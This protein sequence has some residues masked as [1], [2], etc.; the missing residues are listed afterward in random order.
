MGAAEFEFGAVPRSWRAMRS[1]ASDDHLLLRQTDWT[2]ETQQPIWVLVPNALD[3]NDV[4]QQ[5]FAVAS[6]KKALKSPAHMRDWME[7]RIP[8]PREHWFRST[9]AWL[10]LDDKMPVFWCVNEQTARRL[11]TELSK[12][13]GVRGEDLRMFETRR[14]E[15]AG[16][17][18]TGTVRGIYADHAV[19]QRDNGQRQKVPYSQIWRQ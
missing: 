10:L 2:L 17:T 11:Y 19:I 6:G 15:H 5:I 14:F 3:W 13:I 8:S 16:R 7:N 1:L 4:Q 18:W 12:A 9:T